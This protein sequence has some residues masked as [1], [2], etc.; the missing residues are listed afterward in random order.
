MKNWRQYLQIFVVF[1]SLYQEK[2]L[3][4][5]PQLYLREFNNHRRPSS[6]FQSLILIHIL[7]QFQQ[8]MVVKLYFQIHRRT[9]KTK[10]IK[11]EKKQ[12]LI[13]LSE[14]FCRNE[15]FSFLLYQETFVFKNLNIS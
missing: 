7:M 5:K 9:Y 2:Y 1:L 10:T 3:K 11:S 12:D 6:Y 8:N 13:F 14:I 4:A 15:R